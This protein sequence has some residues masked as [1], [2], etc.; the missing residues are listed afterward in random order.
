MDNIDN[1]LKDK[2]ISEKFSKKLKVLKKL[3]EN[4]KISECNLEKAKV[5]LEEAKTNLKKIE[6]ELKKK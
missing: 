6:T 5:N 1:I 2:S 4:Y 3:Y